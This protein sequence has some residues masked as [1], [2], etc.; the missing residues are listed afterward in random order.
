MTFRLQIA[1]DL[2]LECIPADQHTTL[3]T[4]SAPHLALLG[5]VAELRHLELLTSFLSH[6]CTQ[7]ERVFYVLGNHEFYHGPQASIEDCIQAF[8]TQAQQWP[9][10]TVLE[11]QMVRVAG[12]RVV[13][14]TLWSYIP[15][16]AR[17]KVEY[18]LNDYDL[19]PGCTIDETNQRHEASVRYLH[20]VITDAADESP[21]VVLTHHAPLMQGTSDPQYRNQDTKYAFASDCSGLMKPQVK[22]WAFGH[23]HWA[24][25]FRFRDTRIL[26]NPLGYA[27]PTYPEDSVKRFRND[28]VIEV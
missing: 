5:D 10:L 12:V 15:P 11:N 14:A 19:I 20:H 26:S 25:D 27:T 22:V 3:I 28:L 1:S 16:L 7:F 6:V 18:C 21:L 2:H 23:T 17:R 8:R 4:P 13:G 24:C 9:N